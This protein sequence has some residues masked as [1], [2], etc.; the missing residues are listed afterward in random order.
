LVISLNPKEIGKVFVKTEELLESGNRLEKVPNGLVWQRVN[1][2]MTL[3]DISTSIMK[4]YAR[5]L[6]TLKKEA[7]KR[8][9]IYGFNEF[10]K[11][12]GLSIFRLIMNKF[13]DTLV[14]ILLVVAVISFVFAWYDGDK[15]GERGIIAFMKPIVILLILI[16][17]FIVRV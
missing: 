7:I 2:L 12:E 13:N 16:V 5:L 14:R 11:H 6:F 4:T 1:N 3:S 10:E 15:G 8:R 9:G 17:N